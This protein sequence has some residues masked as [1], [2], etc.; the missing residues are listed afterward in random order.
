MQVRN[1][2]PSLLGLV[3]LLLVIIVLS[4]YARI[5]NAGNSAGT[6]SQEKGEVSLEEANDY[7]ESYHKE[8]GFYKTLG[9]G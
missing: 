7:L 2:G 3:L 5:S 1:S 9:K 6:L 4:T 8:V